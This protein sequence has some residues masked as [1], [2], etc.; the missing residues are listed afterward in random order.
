MCISKI[1]VVISPSTAFR[2]TDTFWQLNYLD[3]VSRFEELLNYLYS[4]STPLRHSLYTHIYYIQLEAISVFRIWSSKRFLANFNETSNFL[5]YRV[6]VFAF[7]HQ[8]DWI[9]CVSINT[10]NTLSNFYEVTPQ[11][12]C[13]Y[14]SLNNSSTYFGFLMNVILLPLRW[15]CR[16]VIYS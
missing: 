8:T 10:G 13:L 1:V 7:V 12:G 16:F 11:C 3:P 5:S 14:G 6:S 2:W 4:I 9:G 15:V